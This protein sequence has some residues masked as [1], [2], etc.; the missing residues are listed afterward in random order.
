[1]RSKIVTGKTTAV[2][3]E[4]PLL[5]KFSLFNYLPY[6]ATVL[7]NRLS[8]YISDIY[9]REFGISLPEWRVLIHLNAEEK[10]SVRDI[11]NRVELDKV[12]ISRAAKSLEIKGL[13]VKEMD[14]NDRRLVSLSL[15]KQ[16]KLFVRA[17]VP[18]ALQYEKK[19]C[20][21]LTEEEEQQLR[22]LI[23]KL[24]ISLYEAGPEEFKKC[25][26]SASRRRCL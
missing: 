16:G 17:I 22:G 12:S 2:E 13:I 7:G 21:C 4:N 3:A 15:T 11:Y 8:A 26:A 20:S 14:D 5:D 19:V 25:S 1:M 6:Q 9:G 18:V 10:I 24:L 23:N